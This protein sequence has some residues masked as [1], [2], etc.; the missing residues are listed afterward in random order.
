MKDSSI[1]DTQMLLGSKDYPMSRLLQDLFG[2]RIPQPTRSAKRLNGVRPRLEALEDR[3]LMSSDLAAPSFPLP[4]FPPPHPILP[5]ALVVTVTNS[6]DSGAGS[7]SAAITTINNDHLLHTSADQIVFDNAGYVFLGSPLPALTRSNVIINGENQANGLPEELFGV[8]LFAPLSSAVNG[9]TIDGN[10][11]TVENMDFLDCS[12]GIVL[13]GQND[14]VQDD[15]FGYAN[16]TLSSGQAVGN[17]L[18][19]AVVSG[20][21]NTITYCTFAANGSGGIEITGSGAT[22]NLVSESQMG[23]DPTGIT[24]FGKQQDGVDILNGASNNTLTRD[25]I[26]GNLGDGVRLQ[27]EANVL[28]ASYIGV[29]ATGAKALP[30]GG[31]G[32]VDGG[33]G[34][35]I[36]D[37][38]ISGNA[39]VGLF[40]AGS[41]STVQGNFIGTYYNGEEA[42]PNGE[43]AA[44]TGSAG[45][46]GVYITG[47]NNTVGGTTSADGD[48]ILGCAPA[49]SAVNSADIFID[50]TGNFV[51]LSSPVSGNVIEGNYLGVDALGTTNLVPY[52]DVTN[53]GVLVEGIYASKNVIGGTAP[54]VGNL[55]S[56]ASVGIYISDQ[57]G[58]LDGL[59][60]VGQN[61]VQGNFINTNAAGT[62]KLFSGTGVVL[63]DTV[64]NMIGGTTKGS[65]NL[66]AVGAGHDGILVENGSTGNQPLGNF[67]GIGLNGT[68]DLG[69][70]SATGI[71]FSNATGNTAEGNTIGFCGTGIAGAA[72][73]THQNNVFVNDTVDVVNGNGGN[74]GNGG[75]GTGSGGVGTGSA[76]SGSGGS[77]SSGA[78]AA[79]SLN[80]PPMLA[81]F[82][83]LLG[84]VETV[85]ANG[86]E[87][88]VDSLFGFPLL[89]STFNQF[90]HLE[91]VTI[92][93]IDITSLFV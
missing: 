34:T 32:V 5:P 8:Q 11:T 33:T 18:Y 45:Y 69:D 54:G 76:G 88:I 43:V 6:Q 42:L 13:N 17:N 25:I 53:Y 52:G 81:L 35:I 64:N 7:L 15:A 73:N 70:E 57:Q 79:P 48:V 9:L 26:S 28:E 3:L 65:G 27:G 4:P 46:Y 12:N 56:G 37:N 14:V 75:A 30:N 77:G 10:N 19:G 40:L 74:G 2:K 38:V 49:N 66:I 86:T 16:G 89:V 36:Y 80:V 71:D 90:G 41:G 72:G 85:N 63:L 39:S 91:S 55:I 78:S 92:F 20:A 1:P 82:D 47:S 61:T 84:A 22:G 87:T 93:G 83:S 59:P 67:I 24:A 51:A 21:N 58:Q 50:G 60:L 29:N 31:I 44:G 68:T 23:T 62:N